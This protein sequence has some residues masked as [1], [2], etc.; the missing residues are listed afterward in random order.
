MCPPGVLYVA[1]VPVHRTHVSNG[2]QL[3]GTRLVNSSFTSRYRREGLQRL[4]SSILQTHYKTSLIYNERVAAALAEITLK[5]RHCSCYI[6]QLNAEFTRKLSGFLE[7][8][9]ATRCV[10]QQINKKTKHWFY[11]SRLKRKKIV[12]MQSDSKPV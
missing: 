5:G 1:D 9:F 10:C 4:F 2:C 7:P 8:C 11:N 3:T 12:F 6:V